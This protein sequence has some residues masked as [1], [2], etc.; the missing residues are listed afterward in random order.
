MAD[1]SEEEQKKAK[2][3]E[4]PLESIGHNLGDTFADAASL[5]QGVLSHKIGKIGER[6]AKEQE[7]PSPG[8]SD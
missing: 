4:G 6:I 2:Q 3:E 1:E 5:L 8:N 7:H